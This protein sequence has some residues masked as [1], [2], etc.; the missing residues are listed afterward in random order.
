M[1]HKIYKDNVKIAE[2]DTG[3]EAQEHCL[4]LQRS[5]LASNYEVDRDHSGQAG[6][7][8][9]YYFEVWNPD[10]WDYEL[11]SSRRW[12]SAAQMAIE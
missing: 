6:A 12:V 7:W 3:R 1:A 5:D 11:R 9:T 2:F 8:E 10:R 4:E